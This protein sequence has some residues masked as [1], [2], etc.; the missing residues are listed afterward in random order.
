MSQ[1]ILSRLLVLAFTL[2]PPLTAGC[3][4]GSGRGLSLF[5]QGHRLLES[6]KEM[7]WANAQALQIPREL[8]RQPLP[9]YVVEPGDVLLVLPSDL[10]SPVRLP[11]DQPVLPDGTINL[12]KYGHLLVAG[13]TVL[14]IEGLVKTAVQAQTKDAGF[15]NVRLVSRQSKVYY[16]VGEVNSPGAFQLSGRETVLDALMQAGGLTDNAS[17]DNIILSRPTLPNCPRKVLP[18]CFRQIVQLGDTTTNYQVAPGD[19]IFVPSRSFHEMIPLFGK[20]HDKSPCGGVHTPHPFP[21]H[22]GGPCC[23]G[24]ATNGAFHGIPTGT[25]DGLRPVEPETLPTPAFRSKKD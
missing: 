19:R 4:S 12:G 5:P 2:I 11:G 25:V 14:E 9:P 7:R 15:V 1:R 22:P 13:K 10:D 24:P 16:V 8:E 20:T 21:P 23:D 6:T 17:A 18:V 3:S